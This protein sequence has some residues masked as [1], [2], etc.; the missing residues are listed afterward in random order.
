MKKFFL[1]LFTWWHDATLNTRFFTWRKGIFVGE[2][3]AGNRYYRH[4]KTNSRWVLY[5]GD[6]EASRVPPGWYGW[7]HYRTD[8]P[9]TDESYTAPAWEK[10]HRPNMTGTAGAYHPPGSLTTP[11]TRPNVTGDYEP[12]TP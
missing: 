1:H 9:P 7:L 5:N 11:E 6:P 12:W 3:D 10:P 2:D 8:I 4:R